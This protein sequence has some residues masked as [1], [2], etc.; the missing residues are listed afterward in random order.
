VR[1]DEMGKNVSALKRQAENTD[2]E[3]IGYYAAMETLSQ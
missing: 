2:E 1:K 3:P